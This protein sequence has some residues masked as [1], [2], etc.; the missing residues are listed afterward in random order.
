MR[1]TVR[2]GETLWQTVGQ[3]EIELELDEP[4]TLT[5]ALTQLFVRFP[6][7]AEELR[8]GGKTRS[9]LPYHLFVNR[10]LVP[11]EMVS[12][13]HLRNGDRLHILSPAAGG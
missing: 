1:I 2:V 6:K 7:L 9:G 11:N 10:R 13:H 4:A 8:P 12:T 3:G 5:D